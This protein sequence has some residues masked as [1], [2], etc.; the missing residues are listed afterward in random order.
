MYVC[1]HKYVYAYICMHICIWMY[2][3][4][5]LCIYIHTYIHI[6]IYIIGDDAGKWN[7]VLRGNARG[8]WDCRW[9]GVY[10]CSYVYTCRSLCIFLCVCVCVCEWASVFLWV[11]AFF[12]YVHTSLC[13]YIYT[14][15]M[16]MC[17][18]TVSLLYVCTYV[19]IYIH[20]S[21]VGV[22]I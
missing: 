7:T 12:M 9:S 16:Y 20:T 21:I 11:S 8:E 5:Y 18:Y 2:V 4:V 22:Y 3:Y 19:C 14:R 6:H 1:I 13:M 17:I 15:F 10:V